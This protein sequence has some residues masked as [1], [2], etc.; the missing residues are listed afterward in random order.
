MENMLLLTILMIV[1]LFIYLWGAKNE[2]CSK[3]ELAAK[4][5]A[6]ELPAGGSAL[7]A[8]NLCQAIRNNGFDPIPDELDGWLQFECYGDTCHLWN[9][10]NVVVFYKSF[11]V[12]HD[13]DMECLRKATEKVNHDRF[14]GTVKI[15]E[16]DTRS[17]IS[18]KLSGVETYEHLS[19]SFQSYIQH[20]TD[21]EIYQRLCYN[22]YMEE[23]SGV[24]TACTE[25][26]S[27]LHPIADA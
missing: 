18:F 22:L 20:L 14:Y 4:E 16:F 9:K 6:P 7:T 24:Q 19:A 12:D 3:F 11:I 5:R 2:V 13:T 21:L 23:Q 17:I 1:A 8:E 26:N 27:L 15:E 10:D 25:D